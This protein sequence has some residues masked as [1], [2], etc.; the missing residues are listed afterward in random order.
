MNSKLYNLKKEIFFC[1]SCYCDS[2]LRFKYGTFN[3]NMDNY[4]FICDECNWHGVTKDLLVMEEVKNVK[5]TILIDKI[6][7]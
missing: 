1:P 6:L 5:R 7:N 2:K 3:V 4:I